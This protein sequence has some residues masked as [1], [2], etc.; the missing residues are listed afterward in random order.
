M[1]L[2][3]CTALA[4]PLGAVVSSRRQCRRDKCPQPV[5][6][7]RKSL[8]TRRPTVDCG[9]PPHLHWQTGEWALGSRFSWSG[10]VG[11]ARIAHRHSSFATAHWS[12]FA[13]F[14][15]V[16]RLVDS[17]GKGGDMWVTLSANDSWQN[18]CRPEG[19]PAAD[20]ERASELPGG[21]PRVGSLAAS[22]PIRAASVPVATTSRPTVQNVVPPPGHPFLAAAAETTVR[23]WLAA[24]PLPTA[25]AL[26]ASP[27]PAAGEPRAEAQATP[28]PE[29]QQEARPQKCEPIFFVFIHTRTI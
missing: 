18:V 28:A 25:D 26:L 5:Q 4:G 13:A 22:A 11:S 9:L 2:G 23:E 6:A 3:K 8:T 12:H 19:Q 1:P 14:D 29:L 15:M 27:L 7:C 10:V 16:D 17:S 24:V 21:S 20:N